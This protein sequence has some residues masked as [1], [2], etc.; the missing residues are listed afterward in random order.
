MAPMQKYWTW[1]LGVALLTSVVCL[2]IY[3]ASHNSQ[4]AVA[5]MAVLALQPIGRRFLKTTAGVG[6]DERDAAITRRAMLVGYGIFW[7]CFTIG[8]T[9][10]AVVGGNGTIAMKHLVWAPLAGAVVFEASRSAAGLLMYAR[11]V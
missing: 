10:L 4:A 8:F 11:G 6:S 3:L 9:A 1:E 2:G 7:G 5:G